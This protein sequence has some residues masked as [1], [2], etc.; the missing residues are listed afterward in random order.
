MGSPVALTTGA[1]ID[2]YRVLGV[3]GSGDRGALYEVEEVESRR[4]LALRLIHRHVLAPG[5][6][7]V[8][9]DRALRSGHA[10]D[11]DHYVE[12]FRSGMRVADGRRGS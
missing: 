3:L 11:P 12:V 5:F 4:R 7:L 6:D 2:D 9:F 8:E 10:L 1:R